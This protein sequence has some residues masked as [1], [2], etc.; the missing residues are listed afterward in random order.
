MIRRRER[1]D[2]LPFRVYERFGVRVY[3]IGRKDERGAW[4][5]RLQCDVKDA[6]QIKELR[7]DAIRRAADIEA[8]KPEDGSFRALSLAWLAWQKALPD[9]T[10]GKRAAST[11]VENEREITTLNR[12]MGDMQVTEFE[13]ADAYEY[14]D[15]CLVAKDKEGNPRPRPAKGNKEIALAHTIFE[16][17][18][19]RRWM[20]ANPF[21]GVEKL[22][23]AVNDRLVSDIEMDLAVEI[24]RRMGGPQHIVAMALKT[25]WLCLRRSVEVRA[26]TRDQIGEQGITWTA[27]KRQAGQAVKVGVIEWS[28]ELRATV[29][30]ALAI[31]RNKLAGAW[32]VFGNLKGQRYTKGGWKATL[33][34]LMAECVSEAERRNIAFLPFSL[35]DC[36][37]KGVTDKL[38]QGAADT[39]DATMHSNERMIRQVYDRRRTR[40]AKPTK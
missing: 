38:E 31:K 27:A 36:R 20:A 21:D 32:Y 6:G 33:S 37:P 26:L 5:F 2:G 1:P 7:R 40:V 11:L 18:V 3:S 22:R 39:V 19:R 35:Q 34:R 13:K 4:Q 28:D 10:E 30:E 25:A 23:T 24:G 16:W 9:G 15:A 17:G 12:A 14:L 29:D 8:G